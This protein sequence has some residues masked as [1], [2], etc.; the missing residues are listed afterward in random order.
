MMSYGAS[1]E[2]PWAL[3]EAGRRADRAPGGRERHHLLR[4]RR[5]LQRGRERGGHRPAAEAAVRDARGVRHRDEGP[6]QD[7][8]RRERCG[9]LAQARARVDRRLASAPR[10]RL[11]RPLPDPPL[12][13]A[14][15]DRRDDGG[16]PRRR[17]RRQGPVHRREQHVRL[18]VRQ[19]A[20]RRADTLRVHAEPLQPRLPRGGAGDDPAVHR[21]GSRRA[22]LE[23]AR[24]RPARRQPH[25]RGRAA[26]DAR[27]HRPLRRQPLYAG[28]RLRRR[29][30]RCRGRRRARGTGG[31]GRARL[32]PAQARRDRADR[33][34][35]EA[36]APRRRRRRRAAHAGRSRVARLEEPYLPHSIAG[37]S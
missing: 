24:T 5:R 9:P 6:R 11:R 23:P 19:G 16:A 20:G 28:A 12:G 21:P 17:P 33:R 3:D 34:R 32:A 26:D 37:H 30:P 25:A 31:A 8:A 7:D 14:H 36:R 18:A 4:H 10:S 29:R 15:A 27:P 2:R 1:D 13:S 35:D 22:A